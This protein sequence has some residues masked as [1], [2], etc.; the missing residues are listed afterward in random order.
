MNGSFLDSQRER[1]HLPPQ[2]AD[3]MLKDDWILR[4][5]SKPM[6]HSCIIKW[7]QVQ[8]RLIELFMS[9]PY[10]ASVEGFCDGPGTIELTPHNAL[11]TW[12]GNTQNPEY[13]KLGE[14]YL[15]AK[16]PVFYAHHSNIDRHW[17]DVWAM[18]GAQRKQ[19]HQ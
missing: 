3:I 17:D 11:H 19:R 5:E 6:W 14:F 13:E 18:A 15:A 16:D 7:Y 8:K 9:C 12:V 4:I 10:K 2:A 1:S